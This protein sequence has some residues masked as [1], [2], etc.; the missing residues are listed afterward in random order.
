MQILLVSHLYS[1]LTSDLEFTKCVGKQASS[2]IERSNF[3]CYS[4]KTLEF[5]HDLPPPMFSE[6]A[7]KNKSHAVHYNLSHR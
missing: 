2:T 4:K 1:V 7:T 6:V 3:S 5:I